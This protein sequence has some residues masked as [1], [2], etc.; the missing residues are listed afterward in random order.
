MFPPIIYVLH[1]E[2]RNMKKPACASE[3]NNL[4]IFSFFVKNLAFQDPPLK[5]LYNQTDPNEK[6]IMHYVWLF[7]IFSW[8]NF[9]SPL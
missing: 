2:K 5:K 9:S 7:Q 8:F 6:G 4:T 1:L 3:R